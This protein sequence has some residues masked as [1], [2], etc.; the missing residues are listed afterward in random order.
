LGF[1]TG[2]CF[3]RQQL[4]SASSL[5]SFIYTLLV[6]IFC[7]TIASPTCVEITM[8]VLLLDYSSTLT[9]AEYVRIRQIIIHLYIT[10][11]VALP[12]LLSYHTISG[13]IQGSLAGK[14]IPIWNNRLRCI[15]TYMVILYI[16]NMGT[17]ILLNRKAR[18]NSR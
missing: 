1:P 2:M 7:E 8:S 15:H 6:N 4:V 5:I 16:Q 17:L 10:S 14:S 18:T 9:F 13:G 11:L 12:N 3:T